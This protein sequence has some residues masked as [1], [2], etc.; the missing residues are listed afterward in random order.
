M[1][2]LDNTTRLLQI[3][4]GSPIT[5]NPVQIVVSY[6]DDTGATYIGASNTSTI[7]NT[8]PVT[9]C[10]APAANIIRNIDS[11]IIFN[12]DT[13]AAAINVTFNDNRTLYQL[14]NV[15]LQTGETLQYTHGRGWEA[16]DVNGSLKTSVISQLAANL[17]GTPT[18]TNGVKAVTQTALDDSTLLATTQYVDSAV[19]AYAATQATIYSVTINFGSQPQWSGTFNITGTG[20]ITSAPVLISQ[21]SVRPGSVLYDSIEMDQNSGCWGSTE[22]V[23]QYN[24]IGAVVRLFLIAI[25]SIIGSK[26]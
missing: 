10:S 11:I 6:S 5:T 16:T 7:S 14:S 4:L 12:N 9:I 23:P 18:L 17:S 25:H 8:T 19:A 21:S 26:E 15:T 3:A 1:I 2:R 13:V 20:F 22:S 24:V